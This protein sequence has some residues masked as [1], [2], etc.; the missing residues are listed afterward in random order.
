[1]GVRDP[2]IDRRTRVQNLLDLLRD[3]ILFISEQILI[4]DISRHTSML[5]QRFLHQCFV[6][7]PR[8]LL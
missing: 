4:L 2:L 8:L 6:P 1:M 7:L 3:E 5:L